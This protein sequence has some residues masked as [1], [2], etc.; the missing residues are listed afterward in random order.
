M[1]DAVGGMFNVQITLDRMKYTI[2]QAMFDHLGTVQ[3][4]IEYEI[5]RALKDFDIGKIVKREVYKAMTEQAETS[6][7]QAVNHGW[8]KFNREIETI[9][10]NKLCEI[11]PDLSTDDGITDE[12][13]KNAPF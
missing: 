4:S 8:H 2:Q 3:K 7:R 13:I 6:V 5:E 11:F 9:V 12:D 1:A 10:T